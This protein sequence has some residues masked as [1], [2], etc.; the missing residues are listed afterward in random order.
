MSAALWRPWPKENDRGQG[1]DQVGS[2]QVVLCG[3]L[4]L[5]DR[6]MGD[7]ECLRHMEEENSQ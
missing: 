7:S 6:G 3:R 4:R 1:A 2:G 5:C